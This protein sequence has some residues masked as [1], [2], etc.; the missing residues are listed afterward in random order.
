MLVNI[1]KLITK[2]LCGYYA[3]IKFKI[4]G[5]V[6]TVGPALKNYFLF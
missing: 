3:S 2:C 6:K 4:T 5:I 1:I